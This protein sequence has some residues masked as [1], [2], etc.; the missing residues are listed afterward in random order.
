MTYH[1]EDIRIDGSLCHGC[2]EPVWYFHTA[3]VITSSPNPPEVWHEECYV[4]SPTD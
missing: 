4:Q 2:R 1:E 3:V